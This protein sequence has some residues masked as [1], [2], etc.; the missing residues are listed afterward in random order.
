MPGRDVKRSERRST[1][2]D[3]S[4]VIRIDDREGPGT[5]RTDFDGLFADAEE[6]GLCVVSGGGEDRTAEKEADPLLGVTFHGVVRLQ[7]RPWLQRLIDASVLHYE[8]V[9]AA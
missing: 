7:D 2:D 8:R 9:R 6:P 1:A 4:A 3:Q 5:I